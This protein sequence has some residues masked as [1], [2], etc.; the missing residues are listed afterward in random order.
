MNVCPFCGFEN[1]PGADV[2]DEC[3]NSLTPLSKPRP[4]SSLERRLLKTPIRALSPRSPLTVSPTTPVGE[5]L[6]R[7]VER[8]VGCAIVEQQ[9]TAVGIFSER[10]AVLRLGGEVDELRS[11]PVSEF[12]T[13]SPQTLDIDDRIAFAVHKMDAG[14]YRHIPILREGRILGVISVRDIL[15]FI[16]GEAATG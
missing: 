14:G 12:M 8:S 4:N 2:C 6:K 1:I 15:D 3:E 16:T 9:G 11:R 13:P 7:M 5:V 10:D